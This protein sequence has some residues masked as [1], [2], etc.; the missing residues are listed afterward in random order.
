MSPSAFVV[1]LTATP[2]R[3]SSSSSSFCSRRALPVALR[4][5]TRYATLRTIS[6]SIADEPPAQVDSIQQQIGDD[7]SQ[8][9]DQPEKVDQAD[10]APTEADAI[11]TETETEAQAEAASDPDAKPRP[12]Q[13]RRRRRTRQ[14]REVTLP[15]EQITV[16]MELEGVVRSITDYGAFIGDTGAPTDGLLH[17]SQLGNGFVENVS[18]VVKVGEKITVRVL[19]VDL[20][21]GNL[22]LTTKTAEELES[23][24][25][26]KEAAANRKR[27]L[28]K[29]WDAFTYDEKEFVDAKV[30]SITD[31]GAFC[32][33]VDDSG[34][35]VQAP[36]D[37]LIHISE[38]SDER[39]TNV[40]SVLSEGQ[41]VKVRVVGA[42][43][44][45]NRISL[46]MRNPKSSPQA[47]HAATAEDIAEAEKNQPEFKTSF[48][49]AFEKAEASLS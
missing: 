2:L 8:A 18:D 32:R 3:F 30:I 9:V 10:V 43:R 16:G 40:R 29:K 47:Q 36:T 22:S 11:P 41:L 37:G 38:V 20:K 42:E 39:V 25:S 49:L 5:A 14:K 31:F 17:V 7:V 12:E 6:A 35:G 1:G 45:R 33:F 27:E 23:G 21:K 26:R 24:E 34:N 28:S 15:L 44:K 19:N 13:R 4:P 46:S 48:Q